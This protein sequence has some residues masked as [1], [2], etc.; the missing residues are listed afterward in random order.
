MQTSVMMNQ[1]WRGPSRLETKCGSG[2]RM[3][4]AEMERKIQREASVGHYSS[5]Q[6]KGEMEAVQGKGGE[7]GCSHIRRWRDD[8][9]RRSQG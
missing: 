8:I 3:E 1:K 5:W 9:E 6:S 7:D 2:R 4:S